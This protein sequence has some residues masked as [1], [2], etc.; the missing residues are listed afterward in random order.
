MLFDL[1]IHH[2][3]KKGR[4]EVIKLLAGKYSCDVDLRTFGGYTPVH[5][6]AMNGHT[7]CVELLIHTYRKQVY[8]N[9]NC[10]LAQ[11]DKCF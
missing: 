8:N 11:Y 3:A 10:T 1:A 9:D 7:H 5:L 6:A 4:L 2:A